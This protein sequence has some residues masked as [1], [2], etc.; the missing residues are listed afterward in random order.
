RNGSGNDADLSQINLQSVERIEIVEGPMAVNYGANALAGVVNIITSK[1]TPYKGEVLASLQEESAGNKYGLFEGRHIQHVGVKHNFSPTWL[2]Q[3]NLSKNN[4]LGYNDN[5]SGSLTEWNPKDQWIV[6]GLVKHKFRK[7]SLYYKVDYLNELIHD[8]GSIDVFSGYAF[9]EE[10]KTHRINHV[11]NADGRLG[12]A[13][14]NLVFSLS[15]FERIKKKYS[16]NMNTGEE[17]L[18]IGA[19]D[20][21]TSTFQAV[22]IRGTVTRNISS[23]ISLQSGYDINLE[24]ASGGRIADGNKSMNDFAIFSSLEW[25]PLARL[26]LRPG[27]RYA[28]NSI[29]KTPFL[30]SLNIKFDLTHSLSVRAAYGRGYRAPS[31]RELYFEFVDSNHRIFG[32]ENLQPEKSHHVDLSIT[33]ELKLKTASFE[34]KAG[35]FFNDIHNRIDLGASSNGTDAT[36][37]NV[38]SYQSIGFSTEQKAEWKRL[39]FS[40]G[41][42]HIGRY[43]EGSENSPSLRRYFFSPEVSAAVGYHFDQLGLALNLFYKYNGKLRMYI[44]NTD[45]SVAIGQLDAYHWL[46]FTVSKKLVKN[47]DLTT[48][49]KNL[50]GVKQI[51]NTSQNGTVHTNGS[52]QPVSYGRSFFMSINY[53]LTLKQK[54]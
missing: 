33:K 50:L 13:T 5:R 20:Q 41:L 36:Y 38:S 17:T 19:G 49:V 54:Q 3:L 53:S 7:H 30:P 52:S 25:L 37:I 39:T 1:S 35:A 34:V 12:Q 2:G 14:Y 9:D 45:N 28:I 22:V 48:G 4:F 10:Y 31:L 16:K 27:F 43:N 23:D 44:L 24:S 21:D 46:D 51:S 42:A 40:T 47:F 32:N 18:T 8:K 15:D 29:Y 26:K 11:L 6:G